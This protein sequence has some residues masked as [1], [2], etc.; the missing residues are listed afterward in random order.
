MRTI[1]LSI[2]WRYC[3]CQIATWSIQEL[4]EKNVRNRMA[5][6]V[7]RIVKIQKSRESTAAMSLFPLSVN[8]YSSAIVQPTTV[9]ALEF[10]DL[11]IGRSPKD[12]T[13]HE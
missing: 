6:Q 5:T 4:G 11:L 10:Q 1:R 13:T 2:L 12:E 9:L 8:C 7:E 3:W